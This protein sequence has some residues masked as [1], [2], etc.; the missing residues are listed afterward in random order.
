[1]K[2]T[3]VLS[4]LMS[5]QEKEKHNLCMRTHEEYKKI[6]VTVDSGASDEVASVEKL[7][8]YPIEKTTASGT[9]LLVQQLGSKQKRLS[10][11]VRDTSVDDHCT[12]SWAQVPD[13]QRSRSRQD[14]GKRQQIGG[15]LDTWWCSD[16][17]IRGRYRIKVNSN[18]YRDVLAA[19]QWVLRPGPVGKK[20]P[21]ST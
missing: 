15:L 17:Q 13:V 12:E 7:E 1:M 2:Q 4:C 8:S 16:I 14:P 20:N 6:E 11:L 9:T 19:A 21:R 3:D 5:A 10:T 18:G